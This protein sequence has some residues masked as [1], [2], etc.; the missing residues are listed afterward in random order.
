M[1][2][3]LCVRCKVELKDDE[4]VVCTLH[5]WQDSTVSLNEIIGGE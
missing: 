3:R 1:S 2:K 5:L 4:R